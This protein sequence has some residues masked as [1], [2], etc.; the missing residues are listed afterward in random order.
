MSE[1]SYHFGLLVVEED[2]ATNPLHVVVEWG[3][4]WVLIAIVFSVVAR[5]A[6]AVVAWVVAL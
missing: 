2:P 3:L 1:P 4:L 6:W 5:M